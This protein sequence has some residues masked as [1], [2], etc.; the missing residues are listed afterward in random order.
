VR[1]MMATVV[2]LGVAFLA[3]ADAASAAMAT[4]G[5]RRCGNMGSKAPDYYDVRARNLSCRRA[6]RVVLKWIDAFAE[7]VFNKVRVGDF[8]CDGRRS[9]R[10]IRGVRTFRIRCVDDP[11]AVRWWIRPYH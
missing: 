9:R 2:L 3:P 5:E 7:S 11:R 4:G 8:V 6:R 10:R 1:W